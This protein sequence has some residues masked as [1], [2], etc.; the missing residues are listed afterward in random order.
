MARLKKIEILRNDLLEHPSVR[1]WR[2]LEPRRVEPEQIEVLKGEKKS[3]V[4]RL[5]GVGPGNSAVIAKRCRQAI[6]DVERAIYEDVLPDLPVT[7]PRYYGAVEEHDDAFSWL[8]LEDAGGENFSR[9]SDLHR[10]LAAEWFGA[11]HTAAS[12]LAAAARLPDRGPAHYLGHLQAARGNILRHFDN[13]ALDAEDRDLLQK[14]VS[15]LDLVECDWSRVEALCREMPRT[16]VHGDIAG[17]N[18]HVRR[19]AGEPI[20]IPYDWEMAGW[21]VPAVDLLYTDLDVYAAVVADAWPGTDARILQDWLH[22]G[23]LLRGALAPISWQSPL[24]RY[25]WAHREMAGMKV[26]YPMLRDAIRATG[27]DGH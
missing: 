10:S 16:L 11:M 13:P 26:F 15:S 19:D 18:A 20:L 3:S 8:F 9:R 1:A 4:F 24:L 14:F 25:E 22:V 23:N 27:I 7:T 2:E 12:G 5:A 17:K 6:A 21:G